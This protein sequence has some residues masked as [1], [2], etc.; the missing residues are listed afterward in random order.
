[1]GDR[2]GK[3]ECIYDTA[4]FSTAVGL[5]LFKSKITKKEV[6]KQENYFF[7]GGKGEKKTNTK[8]KK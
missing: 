5:V 8:G 6:M 7:G 1:M 4:D 3:V 2:N